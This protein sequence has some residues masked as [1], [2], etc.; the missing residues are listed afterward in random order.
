M[1]LENRLRDVAVIGAAGKMGRGIALLLAEHMAGD[2]DGTPPRLTLI[3]TQKEALADLEQ[4]L[5]TQVAKRAARSGRPVNLSSI[6][7]MTTDPQRA[8]EAH[9]VFEALPEIEALKVEALCQLQESCSPDTWFLSNTSSIPIGELDRQARLDGRV[10]GFHFYNPPPVQKLLE[11]IPAASTVPALDAAARQLAVD[12]GKTVVTSRDVAGFIG[13]GHFIRECLYALHQIEQLLARDGFSKA[14][15]TVDKV[16]RDGLLRPM[17]IFQV[18]DYAGVD[19][20][21]AIMEVMERYIDSESFL[22]ATVERMLSAGAKGGQHGDG[23][24]KDGFFRYDGYRITD[25]YD[26]ES[27]TYRPLDVVSKGIDEELGDLALPGRGWKELRGQAD[28]DEQVQSHFEWLRV[29]PG[30]GATM[31]IDYFQASKRIATN[32]L[33]DGIATCGEDVDVVVTTGFHHLYGPL[34]MEVS[35][36]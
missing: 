15:Y 20:C 32:L 22:S 10:V 11:V 28:V 16:S 33:N 23:S 26:I 9:L 4:Y 29:N 2:G 27:G 3:D 25:V 1:K 17:G 24:Q 12:L 34:G 35:S 30:A 8:A 6:V 21:A 18:M 31:A 14:V 7:Q 13:N 36:I 19:I 5:E